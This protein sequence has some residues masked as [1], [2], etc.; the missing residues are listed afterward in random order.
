MSGDYFEVG[1]FKSNWEEGHVTHLT[2]CEFHKKN[3]GGF[4]FHIISLMCMLE[5]HDNIMGRFH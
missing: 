4:G 5:W 3:N 2:H 1:H